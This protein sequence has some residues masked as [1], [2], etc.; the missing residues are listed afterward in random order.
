MTVSSGG[1]AVFHWFSSLTTI[2]YLITWTCICY[3]HT[4][5]RRALKAANVDPQA[6]PFQIPFGRAHALLAWGAIGFFAMVLLFN[7]F[8]VFTHGNWS[9]QDFV[10]AYIGLP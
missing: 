4:R 2:A 9:A 7:G 1:E 6:L 8:A 3:A 10:S 5:F